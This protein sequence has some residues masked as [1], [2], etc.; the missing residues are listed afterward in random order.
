MKGG[1][2]G[3]DWTVCV[4]ERR[5]GEDAG[6]GASPPVASGAWCF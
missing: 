1:G 6:K 4:C 2:K 3:R 5:K